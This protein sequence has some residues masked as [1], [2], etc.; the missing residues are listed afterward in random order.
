MWRRIRNAFY[1]KCYSPER[2]LR[3]LHH[4]IHQGDLR[5]VQDIVA[6]GV[7]I[8]TLCGGVSALHSAVFNRQLAILTFLLSQGGES[9]LISQSGHTVL[10]WVATGFLYDAL[11]L[12]MM[13][14]LLAKGAVVAAKDLSGQTVLHHLLQHRAWGDNTK[15]PVL[16]QT[17]E[18]LLKAGASVTAQTDAGDR[19]IHYITIHN[20]DAVPLLMQYGADCNVPDSQGV[21][22]FKKAVGWS[23]SAL[24]L[25]LLQQEDL[26]VNIPLKKVKRQPDAVDQPILVYF[27]KDPATQAVLRARG[28]LEDSDPWSQARIHASLQAGYAEMVVY[29]NHLLSHDHAGF[30]MLMQEAFQHRAALWYDVA[31]SL[32]VLEES[33]LA[34]QGEYLLFLQ[35]KK[36]ERD[37]RLVFQKILGAL[38]AVLE[39]K[40]LYNYQGLEAALKVIGY[41][42]MFE[43]LLKQHITLGHPESEASAV[44]Q[45]Y[46]KADNA[47]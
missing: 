29:K 34:L 2:R 28:V 11:S 46:L 37:A 5:A 32:F 30:K 47:Q 7:P 8:N 38:K 24:I 40:V 23:A 15:H 43:I 13:A 41:T 17:V 35:N 14:L 22:L 44:L 12:E 21:S 39:P 33:N 42:K 45:A 36:I 25:Q 16:L 31:S 3:A 9:N 6:L 10:I 20:S 18:L 1:K 4:K 27:E 19:A 26:R